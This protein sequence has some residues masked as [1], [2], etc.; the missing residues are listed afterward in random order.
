MAIGY[1]RK[2][3]DAQALDIDQKSRTVKIAFA[4]MGDIDRDADV[5]DSKAFNKSIAERGPNGT[6]EIWHLLDHRALTTSALSKFKEVYVDMTMQK[7]V[8]VSEYRN[9]FAWREV[10]WPLYEKGDITQHSIGFTTNDA[11]QKKGY[12]LIKD[13]TVWEGSAV[14][15]GANPNTPTMEV[16]KS[17][18]IY[19]EEDELPVQIEKM[20]KAMKSDKWD[21]DAKSLFIIE[22]K[23]IQ[24]KIADMKGSTAPVEETTQ[25][26]KVEAKS[27]DAG[28]IL[29]YLNL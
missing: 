15:W 24:A 13:A 16:A 28:L 10:A 17:V 8:G 21:E 6:N 27:I 19:K 14:L 22:L 7:L 29:T 2:T 25:P 18:G 3:I 20:I 12:T 9:S 5:F 1:Q 11:E 23:Q 4:S 26:Q